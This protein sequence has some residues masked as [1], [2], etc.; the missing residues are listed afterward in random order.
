MRG[1]IRG[2][3]ARV[4]FTTPAGAISWAVY[5]SFK[6]LLRDPTEEG[7]LDNPSLSSTVDSISSSI[8]NLAK[9][10]AEEVPPTSPQTATRNMKQP[11]TVVDHHVCAFDIK[12]DI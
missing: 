8:G 12:S 11:Q 9:V 10:H 3:G 7:G 4:I 1:F 2:W 5:E 6:H